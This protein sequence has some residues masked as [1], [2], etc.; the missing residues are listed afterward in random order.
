MNTETVK[1]RMRRYINYYHLYRAILASA[2]Y[3]RPSRSL[4]VIGVT[5][6]DGKT[7]TTHLVYHI[8]K[9]SGRAVS[10][11]SSVYAK[12]G[13]KEYDTGLHM[14]TPDAILVQKLLRQAVRHGDEYFVLETTSHA[15]DQNRNWGVHYK[16][17]AITN[18]TPEHLDYH[19]TYDSYLRTKAKMLLRS[20]IA[21]INRDDQSYEM[22]S[23]FA[24]AHH[25]NV[26]TF[27]LTHD[28]DFH[29][30]F[31]KELNLQITDFN[32]Y[33]YLT[34]YGICITLGIPEEE[35]LAALGTFVL[36][37]GRMDLVYDK[38]FKILVDF[39]HTANSFEQLLKYVKKTTQRRIIHVFG[40]A[41]LRDAE[42]R[43]HMGAVSA[44]Y[45]DIMIVT[46]EDHRTEDPQQIA[47]E[48]IAGIPARQTRINNKT[49]IIE[50]DRK[51]AIE[52]AIRLAKNGDIVVCTGKSH[53]RSLARGEVEVPY[54]EYATIKEALSRRNK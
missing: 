47:N 6:T 39:A 4:T 2:Y 19:K 30:D 27:G 46:E 31:K 28:A 44:R 26:K 7:T 3:R 38:E 48:V 14:T 22:L 8:L 35:I 50:L 52:Q 23:G 12:I 9:E 16:V 34:A 54:D 43:P 18:V 13:S 45:A 21:L 20:D 37:K 10:M 24:Q 29:R 49:L 53:E 33:N 11:M 40:A 25:S 15:F 36:P 17:G 32:N 51:K 5:G 41:G 1:K 42:K